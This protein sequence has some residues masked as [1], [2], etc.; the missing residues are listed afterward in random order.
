MNSNGNSGPTNQNNQAVILTNPKDPFEYA[1]TKVK[2]TQANCPFPNNCVADY[3]CKCASGNAN[4]YVDPFIR[5]NPTYYCIYT[6][7]NQLSAF[8]L[9]FF[10]PPFGH[11]YAGQYAIAVLKLIL[12][13]IFA[14]LFVFIENTM[15]KSISAG[16]LCAM[17][18]WWL[19]DIIL[20][21][22]NYYSDQ[23]SVP[24]ASW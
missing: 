3:L 4:F 20:Y 24:L 16:A 18:V 9:E 23:N 13:C 21:G 1:K 6:R 5:E 22:I 11:F 15:A 12:P 7:K 19:V 17:S 8:L 14:S 2:C 10:I